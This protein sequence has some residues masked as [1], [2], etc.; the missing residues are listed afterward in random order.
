MAWG[1]DTYDDNG[2]FLIGEDSAYK[3]DWNNFDGWA[4]STGEC[5]RSS[6]TTETK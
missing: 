4:A 5:S 6:F 3:G 2:E 1:E